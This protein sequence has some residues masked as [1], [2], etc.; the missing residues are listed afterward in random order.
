[1]GKY[2]EVIANLSQVDDDTLNSTHAEAK[3]R[4]SELRPKIAD[5]SL[6]SGELTELA[7]LKD[8]F[9]QLN[10]E[11]TAR[12]DRREAAYGA[13]DEL[14]ALVDEPADGVRHPEGDPDEEGEKTPNIDPVPDPLRKDPVEQPEAPQEERELIA[15]SAAGAP[16]TPKLGQV[17]KH[18]PKAPE[19]VPPMV[20][21]AAADVQGFYAGQELQV[22]QLG[23]AVE[24]RLRA[25]ANSGANGNGEQV[26]VASIN[27][28]GVPEDRILRA[29]DSV[30][31]N[32][33]KITNVTSP[34]AITA[35]GGLCAPL[36]I[37]YNYGVWGVQGRP[38]KNS[39]PGF[40]VERGG[41]QF[42]PDLSPMLNTSGSG[43]KGATGY[44]TLANDAAVADGTD[45]TTRK[46]YWIVD[47]PSTQTASIEAITLQIEFANITSRFDPETL[48]ANIEA[49]LI[50]HDRVAENHLLAQLQAASKYMTSAAVLGATRDLLVTFDKLQAYYRS[51]HR[52]GD[53]VRLRAILPFWAKMMI[54]SDIARQMNTDGSLGTLN[55]SDAQING[56]FESRNISPVW[57][58]DGAA[59]GQS[60]SGTG[61][62]TVPAI[63]AQQYSQTSGTAAVPN[64]PAQVDILLHPEGHFQHLDGGTLDLGIVRDADLVRRNRYRQ[65]SESFE[66]IAARGVEAL[67]VAAT[68]VPNGT[69]TGTTAPSSV[70]A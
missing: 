9:T 18:A 24:S 51:V 35:A 67:R 15:A 56:F 34:Q 37:D 25:V 64:Y 46:A 26:V 5:R 61:G 17:A 53:N 3:S 45:T 30:E 21:T 57:H 66:G 65:F 11:V 10:A 54:R 7:G 49:A 32:T 44:W 1:M 58:L 41:I 70:T 38:I 22:K 48:Q 39:L 52:L 42:R 4:I 59:A 13:A 28:Q 12:A 36:A 27:A 40:Q 62:S 8:A 55:I 14:A 16:Q 31:R 63:A 19:S 33:N 68:V 60:A 50:W 6:S 23:K 69:M 43:P 20:I 47:C 29:G 2:D